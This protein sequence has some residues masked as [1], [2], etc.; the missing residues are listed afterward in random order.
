[1]SSDGGYKD[2]LCIVYN[3]TLRGTMNRKRKQE[4]SPPI[5]KRPLKPT[6]GVVE[7]VYPFDLPNPERLTP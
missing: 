6:K 2:I 5:A 7:D 3:L 1:M 4:A